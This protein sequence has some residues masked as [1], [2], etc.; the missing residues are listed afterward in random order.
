MLSFLRLNLTKKHLANF[1]WISYKQNIQIF[2]KPYAHTLVHTTAKELHGCCVWWK[3]K[4]QVLCTSIST[5]GVLC[6]V[7]GH[8]GAYSDLELL[9][10]GWD[11][12]SQSSSALRDSP[13]QKCSEGSNIER[14][15]AQEH[16]TGQ[17]ICSAMY[18]LNYSLH[19]QISNN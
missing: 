5:P 4:T 12:K 8:K 17:R 11:P 15:G 7:L 10:S 3:T 2:L 6:L 18:T 9:S 1:I 16:R 13:T 14:T 19:A